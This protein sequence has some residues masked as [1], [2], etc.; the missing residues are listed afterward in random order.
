ME[1]ATRHMTPKQHNTT[2]A[3]HKRTWL[4]SSMS[5]AFNSTRVGGLRRAIF[6]IYYFYDCGKE[7]EDGWM[8]SVDRININTC[9]IVL[10]IVSSTATRISYRTPVFVSCR[11]WL[12][13]RT[14]DGLVRICRLNVPTKVGQLPLIRVAKWMHDKRNLIESSWK[15]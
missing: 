14:A 7:I 8:V 15:C 4:Y 1:W 9:D 3:R 6:S 10:G 13:Q 2:R 12:R 5:S 11:V